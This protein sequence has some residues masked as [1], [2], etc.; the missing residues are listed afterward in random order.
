MQ[1]KTC[2]GLGTIILDKKSG[3]KEIF[4]VLSHLYTGNRTYGAGR[5]I[6][7]RLLIDL[8]L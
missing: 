2:M 4:L 6:G 1:R 3:Y 7:L 5:K 8:I